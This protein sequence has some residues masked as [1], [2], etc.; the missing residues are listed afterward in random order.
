MV[1]V[2]SSLT[3][4]DPAYTLVQVAVN[5]LLMLVLFVPI[6]GLLVSGTSSLIVPYSVL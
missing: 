1:F 4:G 5:D 6:I 3:D 2:W